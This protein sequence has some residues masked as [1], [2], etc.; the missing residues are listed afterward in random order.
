MD[1]LWANK[2]YQHRSSTWKKGQTLS[3][4]LTRR[5]P[6]V[7][8]VKK[9]QAQL[10]CYIASVPLQM[11]NLLHLEKNNDSEAKTKAET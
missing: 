9:Q 2:I 10:D 1:L 6:L 5:I 7:F 4:I 3:R 8:P 11:Q